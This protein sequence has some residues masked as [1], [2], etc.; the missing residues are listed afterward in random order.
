[1]M[2]QRRGERAGCNLM[3]RG[4]GCKLQQDQLAEGPEQP[5]AACADDGDLVRGQGLTHVPVCPPTRPVIPHRDSGVC[6]LQH[7]YIALLPIESWRIQLLPLQA[8]AIKQAR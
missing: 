5:D 1:M 7:V 6:P 2:R 4:E 8:V 3:N